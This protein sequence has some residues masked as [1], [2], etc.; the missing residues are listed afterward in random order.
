MVYWKMVSYTSTIMQTL[1]I[2]SKHSKREIRHVFSVAIVIVTA[3]LLR[4][5]TAPNTRPSTIPSTVSSSFTSLRP[6][7]SPS[8]DP[9]VTLTLTHDLNSGFVAFQKQKDDN[10]AT[11]I[12]DNNTGYISVYKDQAEAWRTLLQIGDTQ[13]ILVAFAWYHYEEL[14]TANMF[15]E[16][17]TCHTTFGVTKEER[18]LFLLSGVDG[19]NKVFTALRCFMPSKDTCA[20]NWAP[21]AA[22]PHLLSDKSLS[23]NQCVATDQEL[24]MYYLLHTMMEDVPCMY[25]SRH[26]LDKYHL[27]TKE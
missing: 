1:E 12:D 24:A 17:L 19:N 6:S 11:L 10:A 15:P 14:R 2:C 25:H 13:K 7:K 26:R 20:Y 22:L 18:D 21:R 16:F 9:T 5:S 23:F 4:L 3:H 27:L 8:T